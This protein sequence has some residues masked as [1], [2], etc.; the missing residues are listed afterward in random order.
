MN[1]VLHSSLVTLQ[2]I[3]VISFKCVCGG[4]GDGVY[5]CEGGKGGE[6][7]GGKEGE[8]KHI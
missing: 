3:Q 7:V 6:G 1:G 2:E 4:G 8:P 5:V